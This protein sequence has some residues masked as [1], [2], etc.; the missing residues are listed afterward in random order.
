MVRMGALLKD[1]EN[2]WSERATDHRV[3]TQGEGPNLLAIVVFV[4]VLVVMILGGTGK[5]TQIESIP[6]RL[7]HSTCK[8]RA[9]FSALVSTEAYLKVPTAQ[10]ELDANPALLFYG[11]YSGVDGVQLAV[12]AP[13]ERYLGGGG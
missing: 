2:A 3:F 13:H 5:T 7:A 8:G 11:S 12:R 6:H 9:R 10:K 1:K 4:E